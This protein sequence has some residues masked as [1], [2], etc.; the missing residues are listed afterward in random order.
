MIV[1][2]EV[3]R[4]AIHSTAPASSISISTS[5]TIF[6]LKK[7]KKNS[8]VLTVTLNAF[9]VLNH[10]NDMTY[11]GVIGP[12]G[13]PRNPNFGKPSAAYPAR[14]FQLNLEFKF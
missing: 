6:R 12:D 3:S 1:A 8:P 7:E 2:T 5:S 11:I 14:R 10:V 4:R 9:N 13:G